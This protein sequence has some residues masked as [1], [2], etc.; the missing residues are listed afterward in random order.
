MTKLRIALAVV[1]AALAALATA[2]IAASHGGPRGHDQGGGF[3]CRS[4]QSVAHHGPGF[5][6]GCGSGGDNGCAALRTTSGWH[7]GAKVG[8]GSFGGG[9]RC[10]NGNGN[11]NGN[12]Q[13]TPGGDQYGPGGSQYGPGGNQYG[14]GGGQC[15]PKGEHGHHHKK[16]H[17]RRHRHHR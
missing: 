4:T 2:G 1:V 8:F 9:D 13:H 10:D 7:F 17:H 16:R 15:N 11:G 14:N 3:D 6:G 12:C 5:S